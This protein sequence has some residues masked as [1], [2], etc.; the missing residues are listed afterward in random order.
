LTLSL[1]LAILSAAQLGWVADK[2]IQPIPLAVLT[3]SNPLL[4]ALRHEGD[5]VRV[6]VAVDDS[7]LNILLQNQFAAMGIS[8]LDIS[9][10]SRIPDE[11]NTFLHSLDNNHAR[12]W[13]LAGVKNVVVPELGLADLRKTP[14]VNANIAQIEGYT[15]APTPSPDV[16]S[17][18]LIELKDYLAKA[19]FVPASETLPRDK[20]LERLKDP[21]WNPRAVVLL[22]DGTSS[23]GRGPANTA[24]EVELRTYTPTEIEIDANSTQGGYVL[25][26]DQYDPDWQVQVNGHDASL[27]RADFILRAVAIPAGDSVITL[28]YVPHYFGVPAEAVSLLSDGAMIA[29][30]IVAGVALRRRSTVP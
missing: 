9:A 1:T 17:H 3:G 19:T 23:E 13:F 18:A 29:A 11:Y 10:A 14:E 27:L 15:I 22:E 7:T 5:R 30:W 28:H 12:L 21:A 8:C 26:N 24:G 25:I 6:T 4:D 2:F 20:L 16:P